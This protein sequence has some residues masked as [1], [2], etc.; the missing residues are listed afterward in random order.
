MVKNFISSRINK[1][2]FWNLVF[3]LGLALGCGFSDLVTGCASGSNILYIGK[4]IDLTT[5]L[6]MTSMVRKFNKVTV[7]EGK[8][9]LNSQ[10]QDITDRAFRTG[11]QMIIFNVVLLAAAIYTAVPFVV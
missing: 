10:G 7:T 9:I 4:L 8:K 11:F 1:D 5:I 6:A 2:N 3:A